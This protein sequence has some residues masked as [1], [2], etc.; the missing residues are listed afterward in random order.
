MQRLHTEER[1]FFVPVRCV[2][3]FKVQNVPRF[4]ESERIGQA[5]KTRIS[6]LIH[7]YIEGPPFSHRLLQISNSRRPSCLHPGFSIF[8]YPALSA[9]SK[10]AKIWSRSTQCITADFW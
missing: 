5:S 10:H 6:S 4:R 9:G 2:A 3:V 1:S 7:L 8:M